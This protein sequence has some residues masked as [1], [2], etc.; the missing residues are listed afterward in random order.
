MIRGAIFD[1]DGTILESMVIWATI[2]EQYLHCRGIAPS[3]GDRDSLMYQGWGGITDHYRTAYGII[4]SPETIKR[5]L[6][7]MVAAAYAKQAVP[8]EGAV[9]FLRTLCRNGV[10]LCLATATDESIVEP[11]LRRLGMREYFEG[12]VTCAQVGVGK[13]DP[14]V[15]DTALSILGTDRE[16]TWVFEDAY[17]AAN[18]AKNAGYPVCAVYDRFERRGDDLCRKADV[19]L[20]GYHEANL[21]PF[22]QKFA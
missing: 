21:L 8:K 11:T 9:E 22:W 1:M 16:K 2:G 17:Y 7:A 18:T 19:Y 20:A 5:D 14:L 13:H 10:K 15:Y 4:D 6:M 12:V 3:H